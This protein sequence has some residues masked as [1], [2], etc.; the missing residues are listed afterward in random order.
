ME[1]GPYRDQ[2]V[3]FNTT[4]FRNISRKLK[5]DH[6]PLLLKKVNLWRDESQIIIKMRRIDL[7][8]A[9]RTI[10]M[11]KGIVNCNKCCNKPK[12]LLK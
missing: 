5:G 3:K 9:I 1:C 12:T 11:F 2:W 8:L 6:G 4:S 7:P 10:R